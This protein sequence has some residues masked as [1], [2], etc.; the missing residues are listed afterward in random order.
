MRYVAQRDRFSCGPLAMINIL[1][2]RNDTAG[3]SLLGAWQGIL[4]CTKERP[5]T[6]TR[7]LAVLIRLFGGIQVF[8]PGFHK[9][10]KLLLDGNGLMVRVRHNR[11]HGHV[12]CPDRTTPKGFWCICQRSG[13]PAR[14]WLSDKTLRGELIED[15]TVYV[16]YRFTKEETE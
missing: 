11:K 13:R 10:R 7:T 5:G 14:R 9:M 8:R 16:V 3:L 12:F 2:W 6:N 1:R 15:T 4:N